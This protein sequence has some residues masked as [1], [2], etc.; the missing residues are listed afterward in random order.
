MNNFKIVKKLGK[1]LFTSS[2]PHIL[3]F[4]YTVILT[5]LRSFFVSGE[6]AFSTVFK[7]VRTSDNQEYALK[8]VRAIEKCSWLTSEQIN[9]FFVGGSIQ[10]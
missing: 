3:S 8:K 1:R 4:F 6:G 5:N 2:L 9:C 10:H 7:V